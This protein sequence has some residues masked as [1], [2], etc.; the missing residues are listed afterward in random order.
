MIRLLFNGFSK[1]LFLSNT[2]INNHIPSIRKQTYYMD[3]NRTSPQLG[4][5]GTVIILP[6]LSQGYNCMNFDKTNTTSLQLT[7]QPTS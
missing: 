7:W 5:S 2:K 1:T 6:D 4:T 3:Y